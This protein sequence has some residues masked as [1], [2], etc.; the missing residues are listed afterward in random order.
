MSIFSIFKSRPKSSVTL[1]KPAIESATEN[2]VAKREVFKAYNFV[3]A[4]R[5]PGCEAL[6]DA[7]ELQDHFSLGTHSEAKD[8]KWSCY[9]LW[10]DDNKY[11]NFTQEAETVH[12]PFLVKAL[13]VALARKSGVATR[14]LGKEYY[15]SDTVIPMKGAYGIPS[16]YGS[17]SR[18]IVIFTDF[19]NIDPFATSG[20]NRLGWEY[21][22]ST[23]IFI[24]RDENNDLILTTNQSKI[25][26]SQDIEDY[27]SENSLK[28]IIHKL[29]LD[30]GHLNIT[31]AE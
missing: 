29:G 27:L 5:F 31:V 16:G 19:V 14:V 6:Y 22:H 23:A 30:S 4:D 11:Y 24:G 17:M 26:S 15:N 28:S 18:E 10:N 9:G 12:A 20:D 3:P 1:H 2:L 13:V 8:D 21:G 7:E 25:E